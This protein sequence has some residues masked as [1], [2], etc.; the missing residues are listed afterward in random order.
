MVGVGAAC[1]VLSGV[2]F[3]LVCSPLLVLTLGHDQGVRTVLAMSIVLNAVVLIR[4]FREV[5]AGDALRL[6]IP[7]A[8]LVVPTVLLAGA[9]RTPVLSLLAGAVIL[10]ATGLVVAGRQLQ[11]L[12]GTRGAITAGAVSGIF[13]V[14]AAASGPP[15]ALFAAQRRWS[16]VVTSATLQAFA[17]PLNMITFLTLRPSP[18]D[19][20]GLGW[21][22]AGLIAGTV[23]AAAMARKVPVGVVRPVTL[24]IAGVGGV[25]LV[26]S[27]LTA[28]I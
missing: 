17:L 24:S 5:R 8:V 2:G 9:V 13:N 1:Q 4:S 16:P 14:V 19:F 18:T 28:L 7:A 10:L 12:E 27:G 26:V 23:I 3:A 11:W 6:F 15:V 21:A 25:T 22:V 20:S